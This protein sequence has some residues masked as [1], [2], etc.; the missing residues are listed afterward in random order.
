MAITEGDIV[1]PIMTTITV[2]RITIT[3][4]RRLFLKLVDVQGNHSRWVL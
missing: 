1:T 4:T 2:M 3:I